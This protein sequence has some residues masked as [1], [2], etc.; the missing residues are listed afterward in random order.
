MYVVLLTPP[1]FT[2]G[3]GTVSGELL[4]SHWPVALPVRDGCLMIEMGGAIPAQMVLSCISKVVKHEPGSK[5]G[6]SIPLWLL[7][8]FLCD[9]LF[10]SVINCSL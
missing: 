9:S 10:S 7:F 2:W 6:N 3:E 5:P 4:L 8:Q 1:S